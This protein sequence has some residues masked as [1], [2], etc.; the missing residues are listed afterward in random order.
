MKKLIKVFFQLNV[1][2]NVLQDESGHLKV[3][4]FGLSK[5]AQEK[6]DQ[7]YMM[8]GG[9][10]SC[11]PFFLI[12]LMY[13]LELKIFCHVKI[14]SFVVANVMG[15]YRSLHGT[16]GISSRILWEKCWCLLLCPHST[17]GNRIQAL[18][19]S[20]IKIVVTCKWNNK[21][22]DSLRILIVSWSCLCWFIFVDRSS[23]GG[24]QIEQHS[25]SILQ[26]SGHLKMLDH[27]YPHLFTLIQLRC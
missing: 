25:L 5:I 13:L 14:T 2:R 20:E 1:A 10:G 6:D 18:G 12:E 4:D 3:T 15:Y 7:G 9:T 11:K 22:N 26:T 17:W 27:L 24:H 21:E 19:S 16:W 8:T 23:K